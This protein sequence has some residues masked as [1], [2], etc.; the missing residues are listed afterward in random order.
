[1]D[2]KKTDEKKALEKKIQEK[3]NF[4]FIQLCTEFGLKKEEGRFDPVGYSEDFLIL[5][6]AIFGEE[7]SV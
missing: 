6:K 5:G 1:L 4:G 7:I 3:Y 2:E